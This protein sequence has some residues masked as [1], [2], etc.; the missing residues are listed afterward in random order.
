MT[1]FVKKS[2]GEL[3]MKL[4]NDSKNV[5]IKSTLEPASFSGHEKGGSSSSSQI[6]REEYSKFWCILISMYIMQRFSGVYFQVREVPVSVYLFKFGHQRHIGGLFILLRCCLNS[7]DWSVFVGSFF[8][9]KFAI[10]ENEGPKMK[11][12]DKCK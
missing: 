7:S 6:I 10:G 12:T 4:V 9:N 5:T 11:W 3:G 1:A 2:F 8:A